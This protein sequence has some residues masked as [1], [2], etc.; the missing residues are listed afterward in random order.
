MMQG[1]YKGALERSLP[2]SIVVI[3]TMMAE[4]VEIYQHIPPLGQPVPVGVQTFLMGDSI[5]EDQEI[6]WAVRSIC[7]N[8]SGGLSGMQV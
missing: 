5:P 7:L 4:R 2:P 1:W 3:A 6:S 8:C